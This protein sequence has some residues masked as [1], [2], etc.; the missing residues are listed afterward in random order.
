VKYVKEPNSGTGNLLKHL[1]NKHPIKLQDPDAAPN[2]TNS[3]IIAAFKKMEFSSEEFHQ[4]LVKFII[5]TDQPF[6]IVDADS[7]RNLL[8]YVSPSTASIPKRD[9]IKNKIL[10]MY[11]VEKLKARGINGTNLLSVITL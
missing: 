5:L 7:F 9:A 3:P 1:R 4:R 8:G 10:A 2:T 6:S 11:N